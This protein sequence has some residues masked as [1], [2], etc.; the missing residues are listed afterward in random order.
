MTGDE[1]AMER[2]ATTD[3]SAVDAG[4]TDAGTTEAGTTEAG[5]TEAGT[6]EAGTTDAGVGRR[7]RVR[8]V[9]GWVTTALACLLVL[10]ALIA[11]NQLSHFT[12]R[13]FV[14]IP[15]E[16]LVVVALVL[17][18]PGRARRVVAAV[19]GVVLGLLMI[20]KIADMGFYTALDR[21]FDP[22]LDWIRAAPLPPVPS[23]CSGSSGSSS[24]CSAC[25]SSRTSRSRPAAPPP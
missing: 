20:L 9:A 11:P 25:T 19:V 16:A 1:P 13:A 7:G 22:V 5:T 24:P 14:R 2:E 8:R 21:P 23:R 10:F 6:T 17:V 3:A 12:A 4:T 18:L 15:V